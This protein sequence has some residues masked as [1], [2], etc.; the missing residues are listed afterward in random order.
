MLLFGQSLF[1]VVLSVSMVFRMKGNYLV[2][3]AILLVTLSIGWLVVFMSLPNYMDSSYT[4]TLTSPTSTLVAFGLHAFLGLA[5]MVA[6]TW[7]VAL[8][9]PRSTDF[10]VKSKRI[11]QITAI[12]WLLAYVV[13]V[14]LYV[15]LTTNFL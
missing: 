1:L 12:S 4:Q 5:T 15:A 8:W 2:H 14:L 13:G 9:R 11:W 6:G 3:G 7:V 10:A